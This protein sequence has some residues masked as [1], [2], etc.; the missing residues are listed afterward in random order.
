[1]ALSARAPRSV[2]GWENMSNLIV[3]NTQPLQVAILSI[4]F[5]LVTNLVVYFL[6]TRITRWFFG[7]GL[8]L[9]FQPCRP[10]IVDTDKHD[11]VKEGEREYTDH[12]IRVKV[13][14][15]KQLPANNCRAYLAEIQVLRDGRFQDDPRYDDYFPLKWSWAKM[16]WVGGKPVKGEAIVLPH[17]V[18]D[19]LDIA[20]TYDNQP[21][22]HVELQFYFQPKKYESLIRAGETYLLRIVVTS[23]NAYMKE[24]RLR[25]KWTG[26][27]LS[28]TAEKMPE[29][30]HSVADYCWAILR[31]F[32]DLGAQKG[33][34]QK[35]A[36][37]KGHSE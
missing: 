12:F 8:K 20:A 36:R 2:P 31:P 28:L 16:P 1:M 33:R 22:P 23:D 17:G 5:T 11:H 15:V 19:F 10:F 3:G 21:D 27:W 9:D 18:S 24:I 25:I 7:P 34:T 29:E 35:G 32:C 6:G 26:T 37:K 4:L 14:N 13:T 30:S